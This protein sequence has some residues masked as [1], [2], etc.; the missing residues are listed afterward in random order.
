VMSAPSVSNLKLALL[1]GGR[2]L[3]QTT[4]ASLLSQAKASPLATELSEALATAVHYGTT[5][6]ERARKA[7][8]KRNSGQQLPR[9]LAAIA[10]SLTHASS[11]MA[12]MQA[13]PSPPSSPHTHPCASVSAQ[14]PLVVANMYGTATSLAITSNYVVQFSVYESSAG[15]M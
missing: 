1:A 15:L 10:S 9:G 14:L 8:V 12:Q 2:R 4:A 5:W 3:L 7:V 13:S 6:S 11:Q